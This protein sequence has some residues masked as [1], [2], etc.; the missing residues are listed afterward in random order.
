MSATRVSRG[1]ILATVFISLLG[2]FVSNALFV[3]TA[4]LA[5]EPEP[6][7]VPTPNPN[8]TPV[9]VPTPNPNPNPGPTPTP[10]PNPNPTPPPPP[11]P[12][13]PTCWI[14]EGIE[15]CTDMCDARSSCNN[16][17]TPITKC[18]H[19]REPSGQ[20]TPHH[21]GCYVTAGNSATLYVCRPCGGL[22]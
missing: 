11:P 7:P 10:T 22:K 12:P 20:C 6:L 21:D 1:V 16:C 19:N 8:P 18:P 13:P 15:S 9:P 17:A 14:K 3:S 2:L 4:V 5:A